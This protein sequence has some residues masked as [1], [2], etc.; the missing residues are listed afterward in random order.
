MKEGS[1]FKFQLLRRRT[2]YKKQ[3]G[4]MYRRA[5]AF[6]CSYPLNSRHGCNPRSIAPDPSK[7]KLNVIIAIIDRP[8]DRPWSTTADASAY[9]SRRPPSCR[10][11]EPGPFSDHPWPRSACRAIATLTFSA[12]RRLLSFKVHTAA[13][14]IGSNLIHSV[15]IDPDYILNIAI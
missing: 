10:P 5:A 15:L 9:C 1:C 14:L 11:L 3:D 2:K 7:L 8:T 13:E 6:F 12:I 4:S